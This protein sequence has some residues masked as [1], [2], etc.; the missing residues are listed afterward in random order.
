VFDPVSTPHLALLRRA[1]D[2]WPAF[3]RAWTCILRDGL[4]VEGE[5]AWLAVRSPPA[6]K[7][8][9]PPSS[10]AG[11]GAWSTP[12]T[13][14][15]SLRPAPEAMRAA[16]EALGRAF[17]AARAASPPDDLPTFSAVVL[18]TGAGDA[19]AGLAPELKALSPIK[20]QILR[21]DRGPATGPVIR[22][23]GV[24]ICPGD[25][26]GDR[27]DHGGGPRRPGR[28]P[29]GDD[30]LRAAAIRLRPEL[31]QAVLTTE[32]GVRAATPDGL[33][34]VGWSAAPG[35]M[36]AVGARRNGWLLAPL[37]ADLVAAYLKGDNPGP[38]A[39]AFGRAALLED[40]S[41]NK[42]PSRAGANAR[43]WVDRGTGSH[44]RRRRQAVR[45]LRRRVLAP[46]RRDRDLPRGIR[47]R[48]RRRR[49]AG[50]GHARE[51]RRG[52][53]GPDRGG[54]HDADRGPV[55]RRLFGRQRHP[56]QHLRP[57]ADREVRHGRPAPETPAA[58]DLGRGQDVL[59]G[60]RAQFGPG[61]LQ[62]GDPG[63]EG[64]GRLSC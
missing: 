35:V 10:A 8:W 23:E 37:V 34:L 41:D 58:P 53:P 39:A 17:R 2:L 9:A 28:R 13:G 49:L 47:R 61:H 32:V 20:G 24:Y 40:L 31:A 44:P 33:P 19:M 60:D 25:S 18:A 36:L 21:A 27:R 46:H 59:R 45:R 29:L 50:R 43:I 26:P 7:P 63:R 52:G 11:R 5:D 15:S 3:A 22:G 57:D 55:G 62:P 38:D 16:F 6:S 14:G 64:R 48:H 4:R 1:R 42:E 51:R 12:K 54:D 30:A 56:P